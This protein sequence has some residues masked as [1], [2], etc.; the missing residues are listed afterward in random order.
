MK[1]N[2]WTPDDVSDK[3]FRVWKCKECGTLAVAAHQWY[4]TSCCLTDA[5][6][7]KVADVDGEMVTWE[8]CRA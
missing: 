1:F 8:E 2:V 5:E 3:P 6:I 4:P 7:E